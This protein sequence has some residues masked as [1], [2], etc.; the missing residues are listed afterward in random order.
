MK[1]ALLPLALGLL[2]A[3]SACKPAADK[4]VGSLPPTPTATVSQSA[5]PTAPVVTA[6]P[7]PAPVAPPVWG[8]QVS[9]CSQAHPDKPEVLLVAGEFTLPHIENADGV[10]AYVA[11]NDWYSALAEGLKSDTLSYA[12][13]SR[14]DYGIAQA[15]G[16][17]FAPYTDE[18]TFEVKY[19]TE[20]FVSILR[21]HYG[22]SSGPYPTLL[23]MADRFNLT[24]GRTMNFVDFFTDY[25]AAE[26]IITAEI[27]RQG[28]EHSEYDQTAIA[29]AFQ[30]EY[31]Y[32]TEEGFI[33]Y[34]QP[35]VL[36]PNAASLPEFLVSYS[37]L[38]G[39]LSQ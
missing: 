4:P 8:S 15:T 12:S 6:T 10:P 20:A 24:N 34:Y 16:D 2:L 25:E 3:L 35:Q 30:R 26:K 39:L 5:E 29:S 36:A 19:Q 9:S 17:A 23:Y 31:F 18:E 28:A 27:K 7:T 13:M 14:D 33:F 32:P 38:E 11:I 21:T 22:H 37:L 1:R